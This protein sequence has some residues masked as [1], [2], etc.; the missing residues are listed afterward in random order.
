MS[1]R[2]LLTFVAVNRAFLDDDSAPIRRRHLLCL[3]PTITDIGVILGSG[4]SIGRGYP[5]SMTSQE[6]L[7]HNEIGIEEG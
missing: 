6:L 1:G 4:R 2:E 3:P 7:G 5:Q